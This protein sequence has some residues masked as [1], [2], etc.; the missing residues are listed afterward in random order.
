MDQRFAR[1]DLVVDGGRL[2]LRVGLPGV[3]DRGPPLDWADLKGGGL[4]ILERLG[5]RPTWSIEGFLGQDDW[6]QAASG[7]RLIVL[8]P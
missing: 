1:S 7:R 5:T 4:S 6:A 8:E 3:I 2:G